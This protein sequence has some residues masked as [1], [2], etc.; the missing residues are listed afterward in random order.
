[1][2]QPKKDQAL[3]ARAINEVRAAESLGLG[4][5]ALYH[6]GASLFLRRKAAP[7][8]EDIETSIRWLRRAVALGLDPKKLVPNSVFK[9]LSARPEFLEVSSL[10]P[11]RKDPE[12]QSRFIDPL[13]EMF[14]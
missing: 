4:S 8:E 1:L 12:K 10:E 9:P 7:T 11:P 5:V 14:R 6:H 2:A 3:L 13:S